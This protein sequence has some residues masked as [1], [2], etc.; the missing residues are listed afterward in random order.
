MI[1]GN[2]MAVNLN[3]KLAQSWSVTQL[4]LANHFLRAA[5][6]VSVGLMEGLLKVHC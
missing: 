2:P 6:S 4:A 5:R 1:L 3:L